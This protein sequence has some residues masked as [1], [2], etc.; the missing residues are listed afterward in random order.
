MRGLRMA[1]AVAAG[2]VASVAMPAYAAGMLGHSAGLSSGVGLNL[3][4][5]TDGVTTNYNVASG[6]DGFVVDSVDVIDIDESCGG[7]TVHVELRAADGAAIGGGS[8]AVVGDAVTVPLPQSPSAAAVAG[9][10]VTLA[11]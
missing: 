4:C 8:T 5:D 2:V 9:I 1:M 11:R 10:H 6:A 7:G 3:A